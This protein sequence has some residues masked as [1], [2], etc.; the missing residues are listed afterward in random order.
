MTRRQG[1]AALAVLLMATGCCNFYRAYDFRVDALSGP[2][3]RIQV[4]DRMRI[5][6]G[7]IMHVCE[8]WEPGVFFQHMVRSRRML[9][10]SAT[11]D[12]VVRVHGPVKKFDYVPGEDASEAVRRFSG[13]HT[14]VVKGILHANL[15]DADSSQ[16]YV[17]LDGAR[18][19]YIID[20]YG[21]EA[22]VQADKIAELRDARGNPRAIPAPL[23]HTVE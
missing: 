6:D 7:V 15:I 5:R 10:L 16:L 13:E 11:R 4:G 14:L 21:F 9:C 1:V 18:R 17:S 20:K 22:L 19:T 12:D 3:V 2:S 8:E 23:P